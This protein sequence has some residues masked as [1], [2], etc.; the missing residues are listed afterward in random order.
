MKMFIIA[1]SALTSL[2]AYAA[3]PAALLIQSIQCGKGATPNTEMIQMGIGSVGGLTTE[4]S[5][6]MLI[7]DR[8][9]GKMKD[10]AGMIESSSKLSV[11]IPV[12]GGGDSFCISEKPTYLNV[13]LKK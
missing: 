7:Y 12:T 8:A 4:G 2:S 1:L 13:T 10:G 9:S 5:I 11:V 3:S 6:K